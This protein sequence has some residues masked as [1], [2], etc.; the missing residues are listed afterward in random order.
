ML[1]VRRLLLVLLGWDGGLQETLCAHG[2]RRLRSARTN[3]L[4]TGHH[5]RLSLHL[6]SPLHGIGKVA[7]VL[8]AHVQVGLLTRLQ[9]SRASI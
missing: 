3:L 8:H 1:L 6:R 7:A 4:K 9:G 5:L 2:G